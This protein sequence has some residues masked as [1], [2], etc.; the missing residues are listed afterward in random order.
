ME[1][2]RRQMIFKFYQRQIVSMGECPDKCVLNTAVGICDD[3]AL[4]W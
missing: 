2:R 3:I 4:K 1:R